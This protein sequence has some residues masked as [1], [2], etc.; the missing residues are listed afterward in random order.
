MTSMSVPDNPN[1]RRDGFTLLT[2]TG[3][4]WAG[5]LTVAFIFL[6]WHLIRRMVS[7]G[8]NDQ[9]WSH[10]LVVPL[11]SGYYIYSHRE[12][13]LATPRRVC[14]WGLPLMVLGVLGFALGV[15]PIRND[16]AQGY[17]M[18]LTL[19]GL[20]LLLLGPGMMRILWFPVAFM[21]FAIKVSDAIWERVA[22]KLQIVAS[23][24][25]VVL[26][27]VLSPLSEMDA[28]L[29]GSTIHLTYPGDKGLPVQ[30]AMNVAEACSGLRMLMAFLALGVALAFLFPRTWWQ[31]LIMIALAA[32][33]AVFVNVLRVTTLGLLHLIDPA[34]AHGDF[35][36]FIGM[37]MLIP[38]AGLLML[39]GWCLDKMI[40]VEGKTSTKAP[41]PLPPGEDPTQLHID[42]PNM[43]RGVGIGA[44]CMALGCGL[45]MLLL[46][47]LTAY[48]WFNAIV[49]YLLLAV[50]IVGLLALALY[51]PRFMTRGPLA[52]RVPRLHTAFGLGAGVL[53][54]AGF[55]QAAM[56]KVTGIALVKE[57]IALRHDLRSK[58]PTEFGNWVLLDQDKRLSDDIETTLGTD[59]YFTRLYLD[60]SSGLTFEDVRGKDGKQMNWSRVRPG[61]VARLHVAYYTGLADT[62]PHVPD[63]CWL[64]GGMDFVSKDIVTLN[65]PATDWAEEPETE[66]LIASSALEP[67]VRIPGKAID[68]V[69]FVA[70]DEEGR[71]QT[72]IYFFVAN[73]DFVASSHRVRFSFDFA[74]RYNYYTKVEVIFNGVDDPQEV[75]RLTEGFLA[76]AMPQ[77]MASLPD[78]VEVEAGRYPAPQA[79]PDPANQP[80]A[81]ASDP[82]ADQPGETPTDNP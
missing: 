1:A 57:A 60:T 20:L 73:G 74:D 80:K 29:R 22:A 67:R 34:L 38:A 54:M 9:N 41:R 4:V 27:N 72:V 82:D 13:L 70:A 49:T 10:I 24:G 11:I 56:V 23:E 53:L 64:A 61:E 42:R 78:W 48:A 45:Y 16:M 15:M 79:S 65:L 75:K 21:V 66:H 47:V 19:F 68:A 3:W 43:L 32:P 30:E 37:L 71:R 2:R 8:L 51:V 55:T 35:H 52:D 28:S 36:I 62:V 76:E 59:K 39:V 7:I 26:L 58:F 12:R 25:S 44:L 81:P 5:L 46:N 77:V 18:I 6:H 31:R 33:I 40:I 14:L 69:M 50:L 63:V 17:S